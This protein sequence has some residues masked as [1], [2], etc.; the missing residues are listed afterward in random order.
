VGF[1]CHSEFATEWLEENLGKEEYR[2]LQL[3][4]SKYPYEHLH[5]RGWSRIL[6]WTDPPSF[7]LCKITPSVKISLREYCIH[8]SVKYEHWP[9]ELKS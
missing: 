9:N 3:N 6:G 5:D 2:K 1:A 4:H 8:N 7:V